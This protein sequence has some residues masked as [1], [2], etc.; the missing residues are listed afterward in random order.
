MDYVFLSIACAITGT[1]FILFLYVYLYGVYR[2]PY[3][4]AWIIGWALHFIR[5]AL[6]ESGFID[7]KHSVFYCLT[8]QFLFIS[9]ATLLLYGAYLIINKPLNKNWLWSAITAFSLNL[10]FINAHL[11]L[12]WILIPTT[13]VS[14]IMLIAIGKIFLEKL[15][16]KG[17]GNYIAGY[18]FVLWGFLT[19]LI[20]PC[21]ADT[22]CPQWITLLCG[23]S[24]LI[25][26]SGVLLVYFE[27]TRLDLLNK[28]IYYK[29]L[30]DNAADVVY[31]YHLM[32]EKVEYISPSVYLITG[33]TPT[34]FYNNPGLFE[35]L[36]HPD[37]SWSFKTYIN[38]PSWPSDVPF[39]YRL[40]HKENRTIYIEQTFIAIYD[41]EKNL[42][43]RQGILRDVTA[44][45]NIVK[46]QTLYD[47]LNMVGK[48][49]V[50]I[51]HQ[52]RNPLTTIQGFLQLHKMKGIHR[53]N[54]NLMLDEINKANS[55][56]SEYVLISNEKR[57]DLKQCALRTI[58]YSVIS[59]LRSYA[60]SSKVTIMAELEEIPQLNLDETEIAY[61]LSNLIRNGIDAMPFGGKLILR[62]FFS[63]NEV[64]LSIT[65]QGDGIPEEILNNLGTPFL[66]TK[67]TGLGLGLPISFR[68]ASRNHADIR[69]NSSKNG[70]TFY[71]HFSMA[72]AA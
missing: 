17:I 51:A 42:I 39:D 44:R 36:I 24:R 48:T 69:V 1:M 58:I 67:N 41:K 61:M 57:A 62:T 27:K 10:I 4:G 8:Y 54:Y 5:L 35:S 18:A 6:F 55:V 28:E 25:I 37:D 66:T 21:F 7:W 26:A 13:S 47:R 64:I 34:E 11:P 59:K 72:R 38:N 71:I 50:S 19:A 12:F 68:I 70:T 32:P 43:G 23:V 30:A 3:M 33:Y 60:D 53:E 63:Q 46:T 14:S 9:C 40:I 49:A 22:S 56:I 45:N 16:V 65:D 15:K 31:H 29:S 52:I 2:E 20:P